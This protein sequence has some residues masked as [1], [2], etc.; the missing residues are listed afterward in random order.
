VDRIWEIADARGWGVPPQSV[1]GASRAG[2]PAPPQPEFSPPRRQGREGI[3]DRKSGI[4]WRAI[5][6]FYKS[7]IFSLTVRKHYHLVAMFKPA[8]LPPDDSAATPARLNFLQRLESIAMTRD[9][10]RSVV[11]HLDGIWKLATLIMY[12]SG[13]RLLECL[14]LRVKDLDFGQG[15]VQDLLG[16]ASVKTTMIYLHVMKRPGAGAPS[17]LDLAL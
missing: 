14:R 9:E 16:H 7:R 17:P 2:N 4:L 15:T 5:E 12:G 8:T 1:A 6:D 13:L 11:A 10:V 3:A